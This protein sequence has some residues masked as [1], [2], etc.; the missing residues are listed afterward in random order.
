MKLYLVITQVH[1]K[2]CRFPL[3]KCLFYIKMCM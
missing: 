1:G 3:E 2:A